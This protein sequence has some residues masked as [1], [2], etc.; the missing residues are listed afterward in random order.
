MFSNEEFTQNYTTNTKSEKYK[1]MLYF[2]EKVAKANVNVLLIGESGS[3]KEVAAQYIH[4]CSKRNDKSLIT[5]N[6]SSYTGNLL[7]SEIFGH[8]EGAFTG[9]IKAKKGKIEIADKGTLFLDE[10]GDIDLITQIKLL[11]VLETKKIQRVGS[12]VEKDLDFRLITATNAD[13]RKAVADNKIRE[14]F[15]YRISTVII[16]VPALRERREDL[17]DLINFL[18][19]KAQKENQVNI[20][21][22]DPMVKEFLYKYNYPGNIRELKNILDRMVVLSDNGVITTQGLPIIHSI[23]SDIDI[24]QERIFKEVIPFKEY[25]KQTE[26]SYLKWVLQYFNNNVAKASKELDI[27]SRQLFNK[28]NEYGLREKN[29]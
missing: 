15:F 5:I 20:H 27:T 9:A 22:I 26:K 21:E 13:M 3:G 25:K 28:I 2:C 11:R 29:D 12:N 23:S 24:N 10:I 18:L 16:R 14:D 19:E 6:C 17:E 1:E 7:E 4:H 8:V